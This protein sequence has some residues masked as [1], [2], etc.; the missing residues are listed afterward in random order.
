MEE[1]KDKM[2][3]MEGSVER[4]G[5]G[6]VGGSCKGAA[7]RGGGAAGRGGGGSDGVWSQYGVVNKM[8]TS[9][10]GSG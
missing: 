10:P 5:S 7:A 6:G 3:I 8:L 4:G 1:R 2:S 9:L